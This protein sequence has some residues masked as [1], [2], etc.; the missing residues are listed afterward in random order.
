[1]AHGELELHRSVFAMINPLFTSANLYVK[2]QPVWVSQCHG[3]AAMGSTGTG[4]VQEFQTWG[5]TDLWSLRTTSKLRLAMDLYLEDIMQWLGHITAYL[6][7]E[8]V[9]FKNY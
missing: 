2:F 9:I 3:I 6:L 5:N 4:T 8:Q 1:M 7:S